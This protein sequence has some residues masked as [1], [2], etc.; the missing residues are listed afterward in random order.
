MTEVV[1]NPTE[2]ARHVWAIGTGMPPPDDPFAAIKAA[3]RTINSAPATPQ[4]DAEMRRRRLAAESE[5][6]PILDLGEAAEPTQWLLEPWI[7]RRALVVAVGRPKIGKSHIMLAVAKALG[8]GCAMCLGTPAA[9][10]PVLWIDGDQ[11][12][13]RFRRLAKR[14]QATET[15]W[16]FV[17]SG[18]RFS[19]RNEA[20]VTRMVATIIMYGIRVVFLDSWSTLTPGANERDETE[21]TAL[22]GILRH[23]ADQYDVSFVL[24]HHMRKES[25][26]GSTDPV[27]AVRGS[28]AIAACVDTI[29]A[30]RAV[31]GGSAMDLSVVA[32]RAD[33]RPQ[34]RVE[35][36]HEGDHVVLRAMGSP[37]SA[38]TKQG[39]AETFIVSLFAGDG[40]VL[41]KKHIV[42]ACEAGGHVGRV[43]DDACGHLVGVGAL[44][45]PDRGLYQLARFSKEVFFDV[46]GSE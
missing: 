23:I 35:L 28:S 15:G 26:D 10:V 29:I 38:E 31:T 20:D 27:E 25:K 3:K 16:L 21:Q 34:E 14:L 42:A 44:A 33:E 1:G 19:L 7:E 32:A 22:L 12:P 13:S 11:G 17:V 24:I 46:S 2:V 39:R 9:R 8:D 43:V 37:S 5:T 18:A 45:K 6:L 4:A 36:A 41:E 40:R 30:A